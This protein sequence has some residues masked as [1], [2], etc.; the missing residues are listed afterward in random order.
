MEDRQVVK[1]MEEANQAMENLKESTGIEDLSHLDEVLTSTV[2]VPQSIPEQIVVEDDQDLLDEL[3]D[4]LD[5]P[6]NENQQ[7][8]KITQVS[9]DEISILS[10]PQ[11]PPTSQLQPATRKSSRVKKLLK[12]V[13]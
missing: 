3:Q 11:V 2:S 6:G 8:S 1:A 9:N 7:R 13:L 10:L 12:A 5:L 4:W